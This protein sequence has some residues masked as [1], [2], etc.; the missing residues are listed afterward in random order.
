MREVPHFAE[1]L[2]AWSLYSFAHSARANR[3]FELGWKR[4]IF[5]GAVDAV[6]KGANK[7]RAVFW[8]REKMKTFKIQTTLVLLLPL[9]GGACSRPGSPGTDVS[10]PDSAKEQSLAAAK[11]QGGGDTGGGNLCKGRLLES[12]A[13]D[14]RKTGAFQK[15]IQPVLARM[16][17]DDMS[18][19]FNYSLTKKKWLF[20]PCDFTVLPSDRIG[21]F[22]ET[23]QGAK[24]N[25][26]EV[27]VNKTATDHMSEKDFADLIMHEMLMGIRLLK[28]ESPKR[29]CLSFAPNEEL[30]D[31]WNETP[32]GRPSD[33]TPRDYA[34]IRKATVDAYTANLSTY[35]DAEDFLASNGFD[36]GSKKLRRKVPDIQ[37][38]FAELTKFFRRAKLTDDLPTSGVTINYRKTRLG[39]PCKLDFEIGNDEIKLNLTRA[40][41]FEEPK[42]LPAEISYSLSIMAPGQM[43]VFK[44]YYKNRAYKQLMNWGPRRVHTI[45]E[46][47]FIGDLYL[48]EN[49]IMEIHVSEAVCTDIDD[50]D[51][52][53]VR[54]QSPRIPNEF[55]CSQ[56]LPAI[57]FDF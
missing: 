2:R 7:V 24:Q 22:T 25:F 30:C 11:E 3:L 27:W 1:S 57:S 6:N 17:Q 29:Q 55:W 26:D 21:A 9:L 13:E 32:L 46:H 20:I 39:V 33:L 31:G 54:S 38:T 45:G 56:Q 36:I 28:F 53:C 48:G 52:T 44:P 43:V 8:E 50:A 15:Y 19:L 4:T 35:E 40:R 23:E 49:A 10:S 41:E 42:N 16:R 12:Y 34:E 47:F 51:K 5:G 18:R 37:M 14:V